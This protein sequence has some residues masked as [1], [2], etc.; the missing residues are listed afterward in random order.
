MTYHEARNADR[1]MRPKLYCQ[2]DALNPCWDNRPDDVPGKHWGGGPACSH[3]NLRAAIATT[4][5]S[6]A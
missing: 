1:A 5:G 6:A 3:C 4:T 2:C